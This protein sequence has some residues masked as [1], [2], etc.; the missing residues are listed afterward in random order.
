MGG[1]KSSHRCGV[2]PLLKTVSISL[3]ADSAIMILPRP[4]SEGRPL[5]SLCAD[6]SAAGGERM[7]AHVNRGVPMPGPLWSILPARAARLLGIAQ[8]I[9]QYSFDDQLHIN[10]ILIVLLAESMN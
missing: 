4:Q 6:F 5:E 2:Q 7:P 9:N 3:P 1:F 8:L 10:E